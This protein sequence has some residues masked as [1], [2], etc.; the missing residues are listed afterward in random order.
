MSA[1]SFALSIPA[2][3]PKLLQKK[4]TRN[5]ISSRDVSAFLF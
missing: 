5:L 3:Q 1:A 4:K 2:K